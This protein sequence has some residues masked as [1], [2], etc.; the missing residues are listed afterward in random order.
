MHPGGDTP[1]TRVAEV[2]GATALAYPPLHGMHRWRSNA[3]RHLSLLGR[4]GDEIDFVQLP[5]SVQTVE[6]ANHVGAL[7]A[8]GTAGFEAC[9]S[10]GEVANEPH[11]GH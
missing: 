8:G 3:P 1:I 11:L 2:D 6:M 10:P 7:A 4:L 5:S 9:G